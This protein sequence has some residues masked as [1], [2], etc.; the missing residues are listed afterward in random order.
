MARSRGPISHIQDTVRRSP[1]HVLRPTVPQS[2][3]EVDADELQAGQLRWV[4]VDAA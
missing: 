3:A 2:A 4:T 1:G